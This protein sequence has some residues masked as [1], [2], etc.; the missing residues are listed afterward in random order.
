MSEF[1]REHFGLTQERLA[2]WLGVSRTVVAHA[3]GGRRNLP[4]DRSTQEGRLM[5]AAMGQ[6]LT[7]DRV[8]AAVP[9]PLP[10]PAVAHGPHERRLHECRHTVRQLT[11]KLE[12]MQKRALCLENRLQALPILRAYPGEVK[13]PA[14]DAGWLALF[15]AEAVDGLRDECGAGPQRLLAARLAGLQREAEL[16]EELLNANPP[17]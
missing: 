9:A 6:L 10:P 14:R 1:I 17:A 5:L 4:L 13:N 7:P 11:R 16:L 2:L 15:E 8:T 12:A 3:E